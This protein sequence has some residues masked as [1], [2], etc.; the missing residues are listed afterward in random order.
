LVKISKKPK[1]KTNKKK[2]RWLPNKEFTEKTVVLFS[3]Y[4]VAEM[5]TK[6]FT[7]LR[8]QEKQLNE[9]S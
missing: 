9:R 1:T 3:A 4:D 5:S 6:E 7:D 8:G 2:K